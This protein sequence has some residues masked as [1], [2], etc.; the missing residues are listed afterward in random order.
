LASSPTVE[1]QGPLEGLLGDGEELLLAVDC[2]LLPADPPDVVVLALVAVPLVVALVLAV[3][4]VVVVLP[5]LVPVDDVDVVETLPLLVHLWPVLHVGAA[6]AG[7][8]RAPRTRRE[9][10]KTSPIAAARRC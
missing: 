10:P 7:A 5:L 3:V 2:V 9:A 1:N 8:G 6:P 4:V